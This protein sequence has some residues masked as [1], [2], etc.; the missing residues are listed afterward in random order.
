M[1]ILGNSLSSWTTIPCPH[2]ESSLAVT[3]TG[4]CARN[5]KCCG[6]LVVTTWTGSGQLRFIKPEN[7]TLGV[8]VL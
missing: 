4:T 8:M 6:R 7:A 3:A 5:C 1:A 2:C